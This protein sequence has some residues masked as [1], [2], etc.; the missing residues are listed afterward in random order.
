MKALKP[1]LMFL[2][3]FLVLAYLLGDKNPLVTIALGA[4]WSFLITSY[5][6]STIL[7]AFDLG[8]WINTMIVYLLALMFY[9]QKTRGQ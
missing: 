9:S 3:L 4:P 2:G 6:K 8:V 1:T 5:S 7:F